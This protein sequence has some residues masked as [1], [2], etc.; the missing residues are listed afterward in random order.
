MLKTLGSTKST[1]RLGKGGVGIGSDGSDH[2]GH[3]DGGNRNTDSDRNLSNTPKLMCLL[4]LLISRL[5]TSTSTD[6]SVSA[7]QIVVEYNGVDGNGGCSGNINRKV[8][9]LRVQYNSCTSYLDAQDELIHIL[10]N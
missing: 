6:S 3:V 10:I 8:C 4:A 9:F 7:A 2:G 1:T 5:R